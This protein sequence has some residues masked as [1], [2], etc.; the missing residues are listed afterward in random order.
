MR[1]QLERLSF[2]SAQPQLT[3]TGISKLLIVVPPTRD[4]QK[5]I[6]TALS[7]MDALLDALDQL[8]AKKRD[9]KQS[10]MQQLLTGKTRLPG[11]EGDWE[12]RLLDE[13]GDIRSGGTPST[14]QT[15]FWNGDVLWCTPTDITALID[16][17]YLTET[18]RTISVAGLRYSSAEMI[19]P[20]SL[21]MTSRATI[22]E[23]AIN[24]IPMTT[25]QGFKN[26]VPFENVDIEFL[27]YAMTTQKNGLLTLCGGSTFL[28]INKKQLSKYEIRLPRDSDEQAAIAMI[29]SD[30]DA[31]IDAIGQRR[32][33]TASLK[34]AMMQELLTG[35][36]RLVKPG[37][38]NA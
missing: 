24:L 21:I 19:P 17:K 7:D 27:Y 16:R 10:A 8:I 6:A 13:V 12:M 29:L 32:A 22:G 30:M 2:G 25:N 4:E 37:A 1:L 14:S 5:V 36:T 35:K 18:A 28:E 33:K 9:L 15:H 3:V 34:Q 38:T 23:C 26:I 20:R 11:F 31:Q